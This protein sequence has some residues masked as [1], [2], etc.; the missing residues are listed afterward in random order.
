MKIYNED[1]L[2]ALIMKELIRSEEFDGRELQ[3]IQR[4]LENYI[5]KD[6]IENIAENFDID[7]GDRDE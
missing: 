7:I 4:F 6:T 2:S 5:R 3:G 1:V